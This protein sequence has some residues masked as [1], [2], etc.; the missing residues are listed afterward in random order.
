MKLSRAAVA[1]Y[2][3][4]IF[5][6]G[7]VLGAFSYR[8]YTASSVGATSAHPDE[9]R[10][11]Y[12]SEMQSRLKLAPEQVGQLSTILDET[13]A[14]FQ[15]VRE[16]MRPEMDAIRDSQAARIRVMLNDVQ[17][18]EYERMRRERDENM[19]K[20]AGQGGKRF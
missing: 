15:E 16:R 7:L 5:L 10:K 8:L 2:V 12:M 1:F 18:E 14:S 6:S 20:K 13:R 3:G 19:K 9:W 4:L 11:H 17:R